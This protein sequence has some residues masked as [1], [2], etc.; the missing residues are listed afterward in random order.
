[1]NWDGLADG[2][3]DSDEEDEVDNDSSDEE[4]ES[5]DKV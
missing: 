5:P 2:H 1:M 3:N 4:R